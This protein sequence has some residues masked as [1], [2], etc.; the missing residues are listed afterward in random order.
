MFEYFLHRIIV[1]IDNVFYLCQA[2][3]LHLA[4]IFVKMALP[5][6]PKLRSGKA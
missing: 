2:S 3:Y 4:W 5:L 1:V 6:Y